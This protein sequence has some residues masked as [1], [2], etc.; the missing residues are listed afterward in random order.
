MFANI[1]Q[2]S[3][4]K[5][6]ADQNQLMWSDY[7]AKL[8]E[9]GFCY[10]LSILFIRSLFL[11]DLDTFDE[12]LK[13]LCTPSHHIRDQYNQNL[14]HDPHKRYNLAQQIY[15]V[16]N[17]RKQNPV[18]FEQTASK[19]E[20]LLLSIIP[21][22]DLLLL[23]QTP[24]A[25]SL[26]TMDAAFVSK[27]KLH[28]EY[29]SLLF[30]EIPN[31]NMSESCLYVVNDDTGIKLQHLLNFFQVLNIFAQQHSYP[32]GCFVYSVKQNHAIGF[33]NPTLAAPADILYAFDANDMT[34]VL[35]QVQIRKTKKAIEKAQNR[36]SDLQQ[37][38]LHF[39]QNPQATASFTTT[40]E[41][42]VNWIQKLQTTP[43]KTYSS[44]R[45][46]RFQ[47]IFASLT[48]F[49]S[50]SSLFSSG[51]S[52]FYIK[53]YIDK[54][55][56]YEFIREKSPAQL[57]TTLRNN[58]FFSAGLKQQYTIDDIK[59]SMLLQLVCI[60]GDLAI[61]EELLHLHQMA[62]QKLLTMTSSS[63]VAEN[64]TSIAAACLGG[65]T[66]VIQRLH[67]YATSHLPP[68]ATSSISSSS[69]DP[70]TRRENDREALLGLNIPFCYSESR[71]LFPKNTFITPLYAMCYVGNITMV[72][73]LLDIGAN[74]L[75]VG[76]YQKKDAGTFIVQKEHA[77]HASPLA[78]AIQQNHTAIVLH[79]IDY[80]RITPGTTTLAP[81]SSNS[82]FGFMLVQRRFEMIKM[83]VEKFKINTAEYI[84]YLEFRNDQEMIGFLKSLQHEKLGEP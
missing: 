5:D 7:S 57:P 18:F 8:S 43:P 72:R 58:S 84:P 52:V 82:I 9:V 62:P 71:T 38:M 42:N 19:Q 4:F 81:D 77:Q 54:K 17:K 56:E 55:H 40:I 35:P 20:R 65:H 41:E 13:L 67:E 12:R 68:F 30:D 50:G 22:L 33:G 75:G 36:I 16:W 78:A 21:F 29:S 61:L 63:P 10:G 74:P 79:I 23:T 31:F 2:I 6:P 53:L 80:C 14:E 46:D 15:F 28:T 60:N 32:W 37:Q 47:E 51:L 25:T 48:E 24:E 83:L 39:A 66:R 69:S 76:I 64:L 27:F 49:F 59:N 73:A 1:D 70:S 3:H 34:A 44:Y 45:C 11:H 26:S